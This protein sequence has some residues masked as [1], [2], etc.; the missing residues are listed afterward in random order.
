MVVFEQW[1]TQGTVRYLLGLEPPLSAAVVRQLAAAIPGLTSNELVD[2]PRSRLRYGCDIRLTSLAASLRTDVAVDISVAHSAA[3]AQTDNHTLAVQWVIGPAHARSHRPEPF[4]PLVQLGFAPPRTPSS[5]EE[6]RWRKKAG[7]PI[8][9]V[10]GRIGTTGAIAT[11]RGLR[12]A[13]QQADS[14]DGHLIVGPASR[15]VAEQITVLTRPRW[16]GIINGRELATLLAWPLDGGHYQ[17]RLPVGDPPPIS[18]ENGRPLG[19]S[20]HPMTVGQAAVMAEA[21][22]SRHLFV[23]GPTGSGK[24]NLLASLALADIAAG[25]ATVVIEPKGDLID[26]ILERLDPAVFGRT[27]V[28]AAGETAHPVGTNPLGG[29]T[30]SAERRAD[31]VVGL[32]R[33]LYGSG[34]GPRSADVLL[35]ALLLAARTGG[36]LV[37][38]PVLLTNAHFRARAAAMIDDDPIVLGP[39]LAWFDHLSDGERG[40][41]VAPLLNKLRGFT[42][43]ASLRRLLGQPNPG[44]TW[45]HVLNHRG[46][47]LVSLNRGAIG[48]EATAVVGSLLLGQLWGAIQRR[49]LLPEA[50]RGLA[51]VIVDEWQLF[52]AGL[53]FADVLATARGMSTSVTVANQN[54]GQLSTTLRAAVAANTRSKIS[55]APAKDDA[56]AMA[57]LL[58]SANV[59]ASDLLTLRQFEAVGSIYGTAGAFHFVTQPLEPG[60]Q[61]AS[62]IRTASQQQFG[63][64]GSTVDKAL[65][66]RWQQPPAT[67]AAG[68]TP[69]RRD[70]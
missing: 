31:E 66:D 61:S 49:T 38:V 22:L 18:S 9:G 1:A 27:V 3:L 23:I 62:S 64:A 33:S 28:I 57:S 40:Q 34:L 14:A 16:S 30:E 37:D 54:L 58:G 47:V 10:R 6:S 43:R 25:R 41:V 63:Q 52:M 5:H 19:L 44:W 12:A 55:F 4:Q 24:S 21:A 70:P 59:T 42:S 53:D 60:R 35:H 68:R 2:P 26:A 11:L 32:F 45:D 69:R 51:C 20:L 46:I 39:W 15:R 29:D 65:L 8:F 13:I 67:G 56:A 48:P 36:T 50:A 17:H 7:E